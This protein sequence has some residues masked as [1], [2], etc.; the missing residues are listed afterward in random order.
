MAGCQPCL[1]MNFFDD[2]LQDVDQML[3]EHFRET[4]VYRDNTGAEIEIVNAIVG[5]MKAEQE[6]TFHGLTIKRVRW[7]EIVVD[8]DHPEYS[9]VQHPQQ[10]GTIEYDSKRYAITEIVYPHPGKAML[11]LENIGLSELAKRAFKNRE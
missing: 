3:Y 4:V 5:Y 9:G 2:A 11:H 10:H 7:V 6:D 8:R 1:I